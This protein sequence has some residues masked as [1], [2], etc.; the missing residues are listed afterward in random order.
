MGYWATK[1]GDNG[2]LHTSTAGAIQAPFCDHKYRM[3]FISNNL[4]GMSMARG[5]FKMYF[6]KAS[7]TSPIDTGLNTDKSVR[8]GEEFIYLVTSTLLRD[9]QLPIQSIFI[10]Y[11]KVT[12]IFNKWLYDDS[13]GFESIEVLAGDS[14]KTGKFCP[15][16][17]GNT[18]SGVYAE[19][20]SCGTELQ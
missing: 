10:S 4:P 15:V 1:D 19:Y 7:G 20:K 16:T 9:S 14:Q 3:K 2:V 11:N 5:E 12:S 13:W 18:E 17:K 6:L 8:P